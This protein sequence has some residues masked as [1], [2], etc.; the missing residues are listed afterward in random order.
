MSASVWYSYECGVAVSVWCV[1]LVQ[2][3]WNLLGL[4]LVSV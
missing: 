2:E 4:L 3:T 1:V